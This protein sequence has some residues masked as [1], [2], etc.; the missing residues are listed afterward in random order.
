MRR[1]PGKTARQRAAERGWVFRPVNPMPELLWRARSAHQY[2]R[3]LT[4][5]ARQD[6]RRLS[7]T[8]EPDAPLVDAERVWNYVRQ[9]GV[10]R[11]LTPRQRRRRVHKAKTTRTALAGMSVLA[12]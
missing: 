2:E 8:K 9:I 12:G 11:P 6:E 1:R 4:L 7:A 3:W 5:T 10:R